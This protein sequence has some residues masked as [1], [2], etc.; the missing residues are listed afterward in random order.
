MNP[1]ERKRISQINW[2]V[3]EDSLQMPTRTKRGD[4]AL[5]NSVREYFGDEEFEFLQKLSSHARMVRSRAPV[6]GNVVF[7]HGIM[8][9][10]LITIDQSDH[11]EDTVWMN[12]LHLLKGNLGR[13]QLSPDGTREITNAYS[14]V[15]G[16]VLKRYY[17]RAVLWLRARWNVKTF[18]YDWRK[19]IDLSSHA[20]AKFITTEFPGQPVNLVAH[21]MGGL[22][23]RNFIRLHRNIWESL[24]GAKPNGGRLIMLGTPN[25][26]SF[27][28][29]QALTGINK[30]VR[31]LAAADLRHNLK[32]LLE[33]TNTFVGSYQMLPAPTKLPTS[34]QALYRRETWGSNFPISSAH[35]RR[36]FEFHFDL[37]QSRA[38]DQQRMIYIA[39]CNQETIGGIRISSPGEFEYT[40]TLAG[41]GSVPHALGLLPDVPTYYVEEG[42]SELAKNESVLAALDDLLEQGRTT[43][44][45]MQPAILRSVT[46][47]A[48]RWRR[49]VNEQADVDRVRAIAEKGESATPEERREVEELIA[50]STSGAATRK[51]NVKSLGQAIPQRKALR[52]V[53]LEVLLVRDDIAHANAPVIVV[54]HY[55]GV[56]PVNAEWAIDRH[57]NNWILKAGERRMIGGALGEVF[58][59][60]VNT[61][62]LSATAVALACM[63]ES[64]QFTQDSLKY[65]MGN[66][67]YAIAH[68]GHDSFASVLVGSGNGNLTKDVALQG[69][70]EGIGDM[71][72]QFE[73]GITLKRIVI[74][75]Y[76]EGVFDIIKTTL[77]SLVENQS[78]T[79]L[80]LSFKTKRMPLAQTRKSSRRPAAQKV[81][82]SEPRPVIENRLTIE[83][84][85]ET[86]RFSAL[87][88]AAVIPVRDV[89]VQSF[90][91]EGTS[92]R[93]RGSV[94]LEEQEKYGRLLCTYLL[95]EDFNSLLEDVKPL[96][97]V[98]DR[99]TASFPWEMGCYVGVNGRRFFGPDLRLTRQF[100]TMLSSTQ[101]VSSPQSGPLRALVIADPAPEREYQLP[102]ARREGRAVA[103]VMKSVAKEHGI[104]IEVIE[105]IGSSECD[106]VEVL[107]LLLNESFDLLHYAGHGQFDVKRPEL[108]G[109]IFG[110]DRILSAR[111]IF[112]ARRV[113]RLVVANACFSSVTTEGKP[114]T[115]E[116][117]N[118]QLAGLAEA[119]FERGVMNYVGA[120]W[121][122]DDEPAV[123]FAEKLYRS[124]FECK[125]LG[126]S[127]AAGRR[128]ILGNGSTWGAYQHYGQVN[129]VLVEATEK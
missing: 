129:A 38:V 32:E 115:T 125:T 114:F 109:W 124:L 63:G 60:P 105:R 30:N 16:D 50:Q 85:G 94:T 74:V 9:G 10:E 108:S 12:V 59:V 90:F 26:G 22:V 1:R 35:L 56:A 44:L 103:D 13:L 99:S 69:M 121:P 128:A 107:A 14:V 53:P 76:N 113:P 111:E 54:G 46:M 106:A 97:I 36:A 95:P 83:G 82:T 122:V 19:D 40:T 98:V 11:D 51:Q 70:L 79:T 28:I 77:S 96:T 68:M 57:L 71:L 62:K 127:L 2:D 15:T 86:L 29:P 88:Q 75:E 78:V 6:L 67:A 31:L 81:K 119:F 3:L 118:R 52:R 72:A 116:E 18:S 123:V 41:D 25:Y 24:R 23:S 104:E 92:D 110:K 48:Q 55:K 5:R 91:V 120:G 93:L 61:K 34:S 66:V 65:L 45:S 87:T 89:R 39:G 42:H 73:S 8:G 20:L 47:G 80:K 84:D 102:G 43:A 7:L 17:A 112:R 4:A 27:E 117:S 58:F 37:E 21:S 100:R 101:R 33:I 64:G 49:S 126:D